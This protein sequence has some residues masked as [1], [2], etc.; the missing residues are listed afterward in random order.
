MKAALRDSMNKC[1]SFVKSAPHVI[2]ATSLDTRFK[3]AYFNDE[4]KLFASVEI[5]RFLRL[6]HLESAA[7]DMQHTAESSLPE[8]PLGASSSLWEAHD[9][10]PLSA[11]INDTEEL[12]QYEQELASYLKEPRVSRTTDIY[13]YWH[14]S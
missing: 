12:P 13:G 7:A 9:N 8:L 1:F 3:D 11:V 5:T 14:G 6:L 2:A 10:L 4:E